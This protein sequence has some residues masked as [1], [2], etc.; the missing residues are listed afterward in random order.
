MHAC[1]HSIYQYLQGDGPPLVV[2]GLEERAHLAVGV[3][4][5]V[6]LLY[7]DGWSC[8]LGIGESVEVYVRVCVCMCV[9]VL[10]GRVC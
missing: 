9:F 4:E 5:V 7:I 2:H 1:I 10:G 3:V 6:R 8:L